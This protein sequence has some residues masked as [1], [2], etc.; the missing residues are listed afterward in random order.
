VIFTERFKWSLKT[1]NRER[2]CR[3]GGLNEPAPNDDDDDN[4]Y[5]MDDP[6]DD[7]WSWLWPY[8]DTTQSIFI[9]STA[10]AI[11]LCLLLVIVAYVLFHYRYC[12]I[13]MC[14]KRG[15]TNDGYSIVQ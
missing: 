2:N 6:E 11:Y 8:L 1:I 12:K 10:D 15:G 3:T 4:V 7:I 14:T 5:L 9:S 13:V